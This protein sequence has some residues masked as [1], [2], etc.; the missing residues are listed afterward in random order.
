MIRKC[1]WCKKFMGIKRPLLDF[2]IT[3]GICKKCRRKFESQQKDD[4]ATM[5]GERCS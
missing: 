2:S 5:E 1:A 3:H 4:S